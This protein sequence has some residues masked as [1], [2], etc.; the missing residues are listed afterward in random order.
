MEKV[1]WGL[2]VW[3][4]GTC[5]ALGPA[6]ADDKSTDLELPENTHEIEAT[7][8]GHTEHVLATHGVEQDG[9]TRLTLDVTNAGPNGFGAYWEKDENGH[10]VEKKGFKHTG[11]AYFSKTMVGDIEVSL[12]PLLPSSTLSYGEAV[13][14]TPPAGY[15]VYAFAARKELSWDDETSPH[16]S[17][18]PLGMK[19]AGVSPQP[20][21]ART[22]RSKKTGAEQ[23]LQS[24]DLGSQP[25]LSALVAEL[26]DG[27]IPA[28]QHDAS[29][30][31][32]T[33][34]NG[35]PKLATDSQ[36]AT[37]FDVDPELVFRFTSEFGY[38][39][40]GAARYTY[41]VENLSDL[42]REFHLNQVVL[43]GY[44][45]GWT[46]TVAANATVS[47]TKTMT[48]A[49][50]VCVQNSQ[51]RTETTDPLL[52]SDGHGLRNSRPVRIYVPRSAL[53]CDCGN[54]LT[55]ATYDSTLDESRVTFL[56]S[57][58]TA[59]RAL[60]WRSHAGGA[61]E[62]VADADGPYSAGL[63]YVLVDPDP[64]VGVSEYLVQT[65]GTNNGYHSPTSLSVTR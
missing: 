44:P 27:G 54:Q 62:V 34:P 19:V 13:G 29:G 65:G 63:S 55:A 52:E 58:A 48:T 46:G 53:E 26:R 42:E 10:W 22:H 36:G 59:P 17:Y 12:K 41:T 45:S 9:E 51:L 3:V 16:K 64:P 25:S 11:W 60:L 8:E 40:T 38:D 50:D 61:W 57:G 32:L 6:L 28:L 30:N 1:R 5:L 33:H 14:M 39:A 18:G 31:L 4:V 7:T 24:I 49:E 35:S 23:K 43:P 20:I 21:Y 56:H 15:V 47:V 37:V 2:S